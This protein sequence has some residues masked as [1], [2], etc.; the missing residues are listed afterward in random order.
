MFLSFNSDVIARQK[1]MGQGMSQYEF[2][3]IEAVL[4]KLPPEGFMLECQSLGGQ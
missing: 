3:Q 4:Q 2:D 1:Q